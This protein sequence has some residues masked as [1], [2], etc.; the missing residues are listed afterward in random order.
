[1]RSTYA[2]AIII[3][4]M[5]NWN[6]YLWPLIILQ[7]EPNKT[8]TLIVSSLRY[9]YVPDYGVIM[10][11][12]VRN[13]AHGSN[14]LLQRRFVEA[15]WLGQIA[16]M[17]P[18]SMTGLKLRR[19]RSRSGARGDQNVIS[20]NSRSRILSAPRMRKSTLSG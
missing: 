2:A 9:A 10:I 16:I 6:S 12:A 17:G 14:L 5:L 3:I 13:A 7:T 11:S 19:V 15:F 1:M 18:A 4:F 8:V 20:D